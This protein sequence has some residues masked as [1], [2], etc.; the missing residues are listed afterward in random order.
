MQDL[1][2]QEHFE[3]EVLE[4]LN[5]KRLLTNLVFTGGTMLRLCWGLA[6]YSVDL[7]FWVTK[8]LDFRKIK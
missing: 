1:I 8:S 5:S 6:R 2:K 3:I 7:D 4:H